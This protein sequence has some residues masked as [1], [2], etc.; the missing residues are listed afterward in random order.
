MIAVKLN[1]VA[2]LVGASLA[3]GACTMNDPAADSNGGLGGKA[4]A[5]AAGILESVQ[6][7]ASGQDIISA[8]TYDANNV[9]WLNAGGNYAAEN[10]PLMSAPRRGGGTSIRLAD[11]YAATSIAV[12]GTSVYW[13]QVNEIYKI[14]VGG[15]TQISFYSPGR[16]TLVHAIT[17]DTSN[18]YWGE[19]TG[20]IMKMPL[21]GGTP[22]VLAS[23][24]H[25]ATNLFEG[26][27]S[28]IVVDANNVYWSSREGDRPGFSAIRKV[29]I[30]GGTPITLAEVD[31]TD[32]FAPR[33]TIA[34]DTTSL[35]WTDTA[36]GT[37]R[38]VA[39]T[40][41]TPTTIAT[42]ERLS[43]VLSLAGSSVYF[44]DGTTIRKVGIAGGTVSPL[45]LVTSLENPSRF[46]HGLPLLAT[47]K[48]LF[49]T[50]APN[51]VGGPLPDLKRLAL[52]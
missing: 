48:E 39:L 17:V 47:D 26:A 23:G 4:D 21:G 43:G 16:S 1:A 49:F 32:V 29:G 38:K 33:I 37:V 52:E 6:T 25:F 50:T 18:I 36:S 28:N 44:G 8:I 12:D 46:L 22:I 30:N 10:T 14:P 9:Y 27:V 3:L 2:L 15:G 7:V 51:G 13:T 19:G 45:A 42:A 24:Q 35:Y 5:V 20:F 34:V 11:S 31:N 40:G 41:G